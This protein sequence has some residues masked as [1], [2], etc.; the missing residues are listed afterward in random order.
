M[1]LNQT[2]MVRALAIAGVTVGLAS[3]QIAEVQADGPLSFFQRKSSGK[4]S[5]STR[6]QTTR[7]FFTSSHWEHVLNSVAKGTGSTLVADRFPAGRFSR[8]D[9]RKYSRSEAV[10]ILNDELEQLEFRLLEKGQHLVLVDVKARNAEYQR[11]TVSD[12]DVESQLR[13]AVTDIGADGRQRTFQRSVATIRP[14]ESRVC[15]TAQRSLPG[16]KMQGSIRQV[17]F[18]EAADAEKPPA[19]EPAKETKPHQLTFKPTSRTARALS[20]TLFS[21]FRDRAEVVEEGPGGLPAMQVYSARSP[22]GERSILFAVAVDLRT[23][24]MLVEGDKFQVERVVR[25]LKRLDVAPKKPG[26]ATRVITT[27]KDAAEV[28]KNLQPAVNRLVAQNKQPGTDPAATPADPDTPTDPADDKPMSLPELVGGIRGNVSIEALDGVLILTGNAADVDAVMAIV[29]QIEELSA[30]TAPEIHLRMLSN[31]DSTALAELLTTVYSQ[32]S[33]ARRGTAQEASTISVIAVGRPNA[34]L[35]LAPTTELES[36]HTLIDE[37]DT[38]IMPHTSFAVFPIRHGIASQIAQLIDEFYDD[39]GGLEGRARVVAEVR[40]NT[41]VVLAKPNDLREIAALIKKLDI[42]D[43]DAVSAVRVIELRHSAAEDLANTVNQIIQS[44]LNPPQL[45]QGQ[46]GQAF[47]GFGGGNASQ[48]LREVRS[49]VLEYLVVDDENERTLRSGIL[50]DIR[51]NG[52]PR[53][54]TIVVT[55]PRES[56]DLV[57]ELVRR[58]DRPSSTVATIK[59]FMLQNADATSVTALLNELFGDQ[60]VG[61]N[62]QVGVQL[63]GAENA[64]SIVPLR[65]S[66]DVRTN[67]IVAVG[68]A[69]ALELVEALLFRLDESDIRS[70]E[71]TIIRLKNAPAADI[72]AAVDSFLQQQTELL[73]SAGNELISPFEFIERQVIIQAETYTNSLLISATPRYFDTIRELVL[74]LDQELAQVVIQVL[75]VEVTLEDTDEFGIELGVQE[76]ILFDRGGNALMPGFNFNSATLPN[77]TSDGRNIVAGQALSNF[78]VGR[79]SDAAGFGGLILSASSDYLNVLLRALEEH[80]DMEVLSRPQIR[81]LDNRPALIRMVREQQIISGFN[82]NSTTGALNPLLDNDDAGITLQVTPTISPDGNILLSLT[83]EKSQFIPGAGPVLTFD[84]AGNPLSRGTV[85]DLAQVETT[86]VVADEQTIVIGGLITKS[87]DTR[88]RRVPWLSDIPIIGDAFGFETENVRRTELLIFLTPRIIKGHAYSEMHKQIEADR[89][90][91]TEYEAEQIHGPL[92]GIPASAQDSG[93][94]NWKMM[95][96]EPVPSVDPSEPATVPGTEPSDDGSAEAAGD[97][98]TRIPTQ[99]SNRGGRGQ[100]V[101]RRE[102]TTSASG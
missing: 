97:S 31:V 37:L 100:A 99:R 88:K 83:A 19:T 77:S 22:T 5:N 72:A 55:A 21:A 64:A 28:A 13:P 60:T 69:E 11:Q 61:Q 92:Y 25:L 101:R 95:P 1:N 24:E 50:A 36:I 20:S 26:E 79:A 6:Q 14:G 42:Y 17:G 58:L 98:T 43:S 15:Q 38:P 70:R 90:H 80:R 40:S 52:D 66:T 93:S 73:Q 32:L 74:T 29:R 102:S 7:L 12:A 18:Q 49:A 48:A 30:L 91:F 2:W 47:L 65:F 10:R 46:L 57:E 41:L 4:T 76:P 94:S 34:V 78:M 63:V 45:G 87:N 3:L 96:P 23:G 82:V 33:Q 75:L 84:D 54:N 35:I 71:T 62:Q 8:R 81:T 9:I 85:K 53:S 56:L 51:I 44:V 16:P 67:S 59:H 86:V 68:T 39:R 27:D 89:I